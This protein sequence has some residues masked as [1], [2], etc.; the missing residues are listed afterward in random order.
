MSHYYTDL[1]RPTVVHCNS[2]GCGDDGYI[3]DENEM[4]VDDDDEHFHHHEELCF[5]SSLRM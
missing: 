3:N 4:Q 5:I 2:G 1:R